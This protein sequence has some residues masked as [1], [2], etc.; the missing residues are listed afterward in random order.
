[1]PLVLWLLATLALSVLPVSG[2]S[3]V[4]NQDKAGHFAMYG[5]GAIL[6][7]RM[8]VRRYLAVQA[9]GFAVLAASLYGCLMEA[10]QAFLSFRQASLADIFSNAAGALLCCTIYAR[11]KGHEA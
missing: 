1:M 9:L 5:I 11:W 4:E 6:F 10:F 2:P 3:V 8:L 7:Y